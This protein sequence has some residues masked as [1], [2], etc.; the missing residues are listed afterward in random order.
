MDILKISL[1]FLL[2]L[3]PIAELGKFHL[4]LI[5]F[6]I[7][8]LLMGSVVIAWIF[9][10]KFS[11]QNVLLKE[12]MLVVFA[13]FS[14]SL[15]LNIGWLELPDFFISLLYLIR[16]LLYASLY[17]IILSLDKKFIQKLKL[18]LIIPIS[19]FL[20]SGYIQ[21]FLYQNLRNLYYLGWDEHLYRLFSTFLD[22]NFAGTFFVLTF[23][24]LLYL[25]FSNLEN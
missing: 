6:S 24:Y 17:A 13:T 21:F 22:P 4:G 10:H 15:L 12:P 25:V 5:S 19:L 11:L 14:T 3:F 9:K 20:I 8:D 16:L 2:L 7:N 23:I 18:F 1:I